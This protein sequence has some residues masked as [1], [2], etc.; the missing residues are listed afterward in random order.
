MSVDIHPTALV[1]KGAQLA[2]GV[3]I[4]PYCIIGEH[5]EIGAR[6]QVLAHVVIEN[7]TRIGEDCSIRNFS[8]LGGP[9]HHTGYKG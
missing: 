7:R 9:P 8:N 3:S 4:G 6:T 5:V 1:A 2:D